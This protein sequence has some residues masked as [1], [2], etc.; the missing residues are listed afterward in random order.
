M[1]TRIFGGRALSPDRREK[2]CAFLRGVAALSGGEEDEETDVT[3]CVAVEFDVATGGA[4]YSDVKAA[5]EAALEGCEAKVRFVML[6]CGRE[7]SFL[8]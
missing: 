3:A 4:L 1:C 8:L 7:R 6:V 5:A 2:L